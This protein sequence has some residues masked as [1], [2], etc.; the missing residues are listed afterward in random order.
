LEELEKKL[1]EIQKNILSLRKKPKSLYCTVDGI[2]Y[3]ILVSIIKKQQEILTSL[4][5]RKNNG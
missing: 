3:N 5:K 2:D 1:E 4:V